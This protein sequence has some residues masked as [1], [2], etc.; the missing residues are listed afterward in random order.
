MQHTAPLPPIGS[1]VTVRFIGDSCVSKS[2]LHGTVTDHDSKDGK[3]I[4]GYEAPVT[5]TDGRIVRTTK[6]AWLDQLVGSEP[7]VLLA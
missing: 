3:P 5:L 1:K 7:T 4:F 2:L 6:W